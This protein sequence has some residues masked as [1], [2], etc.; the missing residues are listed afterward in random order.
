MSMIHADELQPGDIVE[1][2]GV[3]HAV[4]QVDRR[5]GWA[6]PIVSDGRAGRSPSTTTSSTSCAP[7]VRAT[8]SR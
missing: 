5:P 3:L 7:P 1:Y 2:R 4:R 6:W 8:M